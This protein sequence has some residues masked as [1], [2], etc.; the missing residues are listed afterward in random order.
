MGCREI[1]W[2]GT[3][4]S[5]I[6]FHQENGDVVHL[7]VVETEG[8]SE[9]EM[10]K[11]GILD[12]RNGLETQGWRDEKYAYLYVGSSPEVSLAGLL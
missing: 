10:D 9:V 11:L 12:R 6:C 8:M 5:L 3:K 7:F 2:N 4:V 1:D